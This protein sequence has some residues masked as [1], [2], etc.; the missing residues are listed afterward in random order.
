MSADWQVSS[1]T[2]SCC[3]TRQLFEV[4][5]VYYSALKED[6]EGFSR[7]DFSSDAWE[8][9]EKDVFFSFWKTRA[10]EPEE[11][12]RRK[13]VI[14]IEAFYTFFSSLEDAKD[15]SKALFKYLVALILTRKRV[16]RLDEIEKSPDGD[17]L[18]LYNR[19]SEKE[20]R[21]LSPDATDEQLAEVQENLN[22]IFDCQM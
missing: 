16:F 15:D 11:D 6:G 19:R 4:G 20:L 17:Y 2:H 9:E 7:L 21:I 1:S 12:K 3:V 5:E 22:Q 13:L 10:R 14:D 18:L 8:K